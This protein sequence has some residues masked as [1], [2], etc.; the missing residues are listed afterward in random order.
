MLTQS[1][2]RDKGSG[3]AWSG[4]RMKAFCVAILAIICALLVFFRGAFF[5]R[6]AVDFQVLLLSLSFFFEGVVD[7]LSVVV[8]LFVRSADLDASLACSAVLP[9]VWQIR[10]CRFS[11]ALRSSSSIL[12]PM[13]CTGFRQSRHL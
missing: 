9:R 7:E 3:V 12:H 1:V 10:H 13:E 11:W 8:F 5:F 4:C 6:D 2:L